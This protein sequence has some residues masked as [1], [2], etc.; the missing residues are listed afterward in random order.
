MI[1]SN[2]LLG[3]RIAFFDKGAAGSARS[4]GADAVGAPDLP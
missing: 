2:I 1:R 3:A 4:V